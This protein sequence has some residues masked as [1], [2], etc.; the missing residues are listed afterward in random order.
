MATYTRIY[1]FV[2]CDQTLCEEQKERQSEQEM[3]PVPPGSH[4]HWAGVAITRLPCVPH[5]CE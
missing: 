4:N 2:A 3:A 5:P 1:E